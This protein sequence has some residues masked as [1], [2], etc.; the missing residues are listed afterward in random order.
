MSGTLFNGVQVWVE[1]SKIFKYFSCKIHSLLVES[2][3]TI[4]FVFSLRKISA[5]RL[6]PDMNV[7][8]RKSIWKFLSV[9]LIPGPH[10]T[11]FHSY[12]DP[13][14]L[15]VPLISGPHLDKFSTLTW[16]PSCWMFHSYLYPYGTYVPLIP[17]PHHCKCSI[18]TWTPLYTVILEPLLIKLNFWN[19]SKF[20]AW[21]NKCNNKW[22]L[23]WF[24]VQ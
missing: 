23:F 20:R 9:P 24:Y 13:F 16:T 14:M 1:R 11:T 10:W 5:Y 18:H 22:I 8:C 21:S 3:W 19:K 15:D 17:W 7:F 2:D 4:R 6:W 12:L